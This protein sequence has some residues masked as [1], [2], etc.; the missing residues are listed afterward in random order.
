M[1][2]ILVI[3]VLCCMIS[4]QALASFV[5]E[6]KIYTQEEIVELKD[7]VL[8]KVYIDTMIEKKTSEAFHD[9]AGFSPREYEN[10]RALL[11]L[12]VRLRQ[13]LAR[14]AID[15]PPVSEWLN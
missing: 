12:V 2:K 1:K 7:N 9:R 10:Y 15:V 6:V 11:A 3:L 8:V 14:R 5:Y 13:E 4:T